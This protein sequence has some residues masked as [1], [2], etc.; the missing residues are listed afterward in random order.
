MSSQSLQADKNNLSSISVK[1]RSSS[2][3]PKGSCKLKKRNIKVV[4]MFFHIH[5][6]RV[7]SENSILKKICS[8]Q[9]FIYTVP[10][11]KLIT[12]QLHYIRC[13]LDFCFYRYQTLLHD[14]WQRLPL[15]IGR[16]LSM[17]LHWHHLPW[18][19]MCLWAHVCV[20][21]SICSSENQ[22]LWNS[23]LPTVS[24]QKRNL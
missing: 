10:I 3:S 20:C 9:I 12:S 17:V 6:C 24:C 19:K 15:W 23:N 5:L 14:K 11:A 2:P 22:S 7:V 21:V 18:H 13:M 16:N 1:E 8:N 4:L